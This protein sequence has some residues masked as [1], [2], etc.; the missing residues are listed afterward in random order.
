VPRPWIGAR[1]RAHPL[2]LGA[3]LPTRR[4]RSA[5]TAPPPRLGH[6]A[7]DLGPH[8][9][10]RD[11]AAQGA[12]DA[13]DLDPRRHPAARGLPPGRAFLSPLHPR[14]PPRPARHEPSP[15]SRRGRKPAHHQD[16]LRLVRRPVGRRLPPRTAGARTR[17]PN[18][19]GQA[20]G[21]HRPTPRAFRW[22]IAGTWPKTSRR[23]ATRCSGHSC[24][25]A[26]RTRST[27]TAVPSIAPSSSRTRSTGSTV[28]SF[29]PAPTTARDGE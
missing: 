18:H 22:P 4:P 17:R 7:G 11:C 5:G 8:P 23:C 20:G 29:I 25:G 16:A 27:S 21:L 13:L 3:T 24:A 1:R 6:P 12:A 15:A 14:S 9:R 10:A 2:R 26:R 19:H 28:I